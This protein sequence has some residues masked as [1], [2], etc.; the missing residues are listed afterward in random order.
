MSGD[1]FS[2]SEEIVVNGAGPSFVNEFDNEREARERAEADLN[3]L[4]RAF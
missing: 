2:G 4:L 3:R 1:S